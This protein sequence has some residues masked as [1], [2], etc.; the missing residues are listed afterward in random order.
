[1]A[2]YLVHKWFGV[3]LC[4]GRKVSRFLVFPRDPQEI[5][6]RIRAVQMGDILDEEKELMFRG[7]LF[8]DPRMAAMGKVVDFNSDFI[9]PEDYGFSEEILRDAMLLVAQM[10]MSYTVP[11]EK[12]IIQAV[13]ALD[14]LTGKANLLAERVRVWYSLYFP[15]LPSMVNGEEEMV[16]LIAEYGTRDEIIAALREKGA[17]IDEESI[18]R[19]EVSE[20]DMAA[21]CSLAALAAATYE[22]MRVINDYIEKSME[23][24]APNLSAVIGPILGA[25]LMALAGGLKRLATLPAGTVQLLGAEAAMFRHI[26]EG[27]AGPKHGVIFQHPMLHSAPPWQRGSIARAVAGKISIAARA[28][29]FGGADISER[30]KEELEARLEEIRKSKKDAPLRRK[31]KGG[32]K[33]ADSRGRSDRK[34]R[35]DGMDG[36]RK[37]G[38]S[39]KARPN[40]GGRDFREERNSH[41]LGTGRK[42][43]RKNFKEKR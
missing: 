40:S 28:D 27:S 13:E 37:G 35:G 21:I 38:N 18:F 7:I 12:L 36:K 10:D 9:V 39:R 34:G 26:K 43:G 8:T 42:K 31:G 29:A 24:I 20:Y 23:E 4:E 41:S 15:E 19:R 16:R 32:R 14:D 25:R 3:F 33:K 11:R 5:A 2:K 22:E 1:M 17:D 6:E 30:L